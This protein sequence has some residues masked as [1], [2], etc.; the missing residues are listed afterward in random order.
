[1][2]NQELYKVLEGNDDLGVVI[3]SHIIVEQSLNLLIESKMK[4][5][6]SYRKLQLEFSQLVKLAVALGLTKDLE[7]ILN[8]LGKLRNT[9]AH[10]LKPCITQSDANNLYGALGPNEKQ[11]LQR[12]LTLLKNIDQH[13]AMPSFPS[14]PPKEKYIVCIIS[15]CAVLQVAI[16]KIRIITI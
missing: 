5:V 1:M 9:F 15:V 10:Q 7:P 16:E 2:L 8:S 14:M 4:N 13:K 3:R 12:S 11:F 6:E